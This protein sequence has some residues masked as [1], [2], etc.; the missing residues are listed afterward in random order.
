MPESDKDSAD[1]PAPLSLANTAAMADPKLMLGCMLPGYKNDIDEMG[2]SNVM[3]CEY[4]L[5]FGVSRHLYGVHLHTRNFYWF[6]SLVLTRT[7]Q[8]Q[9]HRV[10]GARQSKTE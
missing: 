8:A 7:S 5:F 9:I 1:V 6:G 3:G 2:Y 10:N 4:L